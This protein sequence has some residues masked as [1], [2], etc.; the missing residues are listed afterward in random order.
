MGIAR[1]VLQHWYH[2]RREENIPNNERDM[3]MQKALSQLSQKGVGSVSQPR[4]LRFFATEP[5]GSG[6]V[7]GS[8]PKNRLKTTLRH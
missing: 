1:R 4:F 5:R 3:M 2:V 8:V 6:S 7:R